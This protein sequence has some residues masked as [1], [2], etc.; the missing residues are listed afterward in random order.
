[1]QLHTKRW[2][3]FQKMLIMT[4]TRIPLELGQTMKFVSGWQISSVEYSLNTDIKDSNF[5]YSHRIDIRPRTSTKFQKIWTGSDVPRRRSSKRTGT[6]PLAAETASDYNSK[7]YK[8][9]HQLE[10][11][12]VQYTFIK[13]DLCLAV[14]C[15]HEFRFIIRT[16]ILL[17]V[18]VAFLQE[19]LRYYYTRVTFY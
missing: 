17:H 18:V 11:F 4:K 1:M 6:F 19:R 12:K 7:L 13:L 16:Q 5:I 9:L 14:L 10:R 15:L 3:S 2:Q 8:S